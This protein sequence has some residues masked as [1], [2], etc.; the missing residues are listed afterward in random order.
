MPQS[1]RQQTAPAVP[2]AGPGPA[3]PDDGPGDGPVTVGAVIETLETAYPPGTAESWD[4]VGL[5]CGDP[6]EHVT[7]VLLAVDPVEEVVAEAERLGADLIVVHHP[8]LLRGV[9]SVATDTPKGR[10]VH[11]LIRSGI[12][13]YCAHTNADSARGGVNEALAEL[14]GLADLTPLQPAESG[15]SS[16]GI[17]RV[18][19]LRVP[20]T[21]QELAHRLAEVLPPT[22]HG[23][24][25]S[26]PLEAPVARVALCGGAGDSL[27]GEVRASGA[28]VYVTADLRHHPASEARAHRVDGRPYLLD[29]SHWASEWP[30]L[31]RC[32]DLLRA[33]WPALDVHVSR[34]C[35]DPWNHIVPTPGGAS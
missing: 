16:T 15:D 7:T 9:H 1:P 32:A 11:R 24:R 13:L 19:R 30:W 22:A 26:G 23:V 10:V 27:F 12:A 5:V 4:R 21:L 8:L 33:T 25:V 31:P 28:D 6:A 17:G 29:L 3:A 14:L 34:R 20:A 35:T 18:G 2:A